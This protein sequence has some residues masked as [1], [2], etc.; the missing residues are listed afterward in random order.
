MPFWHGVVRSAWSGI[1]SLRA[2]RCR[3]GYVES[4]NGHMRGELLNETLL[5]SLAL[6]RVG[7]AAWVE[8]YNWE[9]PHS[10]L[11]YAIPA[12]F[13]A[14]LDKQ[15]PASLRPTGSATQAIAST[16]QMRKTTARL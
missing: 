16:A 9:R 10:S 11:G 8:D 14:E 2:D 13:A 1:T 3:T 15:W 12:A 4:F 7:I 6:A 5:M